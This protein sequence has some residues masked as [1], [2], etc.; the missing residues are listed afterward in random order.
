[1]LY[2]RPGKEARQ[3]GM[4]KN[5]ITPP[6]KL[7]KLQRKMEGRKARARSIDKMPTGFYSTSASTDLPSKIT[8]R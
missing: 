1:M 2:P 5:A 3:D 4:P 8:Q 7:Q 6:A